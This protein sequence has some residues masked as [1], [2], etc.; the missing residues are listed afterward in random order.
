MTAGTDGSTPKPSTLR[1]QWQQLAEVQQARGQFSLAHI[2]H[3][4]EPARRWLTHS[5]AVGTPLAST[6]QLSMHGQI[7]IGRWRRFTADQII[8]LPYGFIWAATTRFAGIPVTGFD[9]YTNGTG[10]MRWRLA[11]PIPFMSGAGPDITRSAAG[12]LAA[13][14]TALLPTGYHNAAWSSPD[15]DT[16]VAT[17]TIDGQLEEVHLHIGPNGELNDILI[18]RWGNP[19]GRQHARY[20]FRVAVDLERTFD[21]ITIPAQFRA[22]WST[23]PEHPGNGDFFHAEIT[24]AT[25]R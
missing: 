12:R 18:H 9:R 20:P 25:F 8:N 11:G 17:G 7:R 5:I 1:Q 10:Q 3:L 23:P 24:T 15:P 6:V 16:A 19:D 4:P 22:R 13:E 21:G 14:G 2:A